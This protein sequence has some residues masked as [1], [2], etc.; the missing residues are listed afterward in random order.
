MAIWTAILC[1]AIS[2][3]GTV[4]MR[5]FQT[6][7]SIGCLLGVVVVMANQCLILVAIFGAEAQREKSRKR[8][9]DDVFVVFMFFLC[10]AYL[11]FASL[12]AV[13]RNEL[14][15]EFPTRPPAPPEA[16]LAVPE[17]AVIEPAA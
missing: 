12:L 6:A 16:Q 1:M 5:K 14:I 7:F 15:K 13:F 3:G 2:V 8:Q 17:G 11:F 9:T 10:V 4:V